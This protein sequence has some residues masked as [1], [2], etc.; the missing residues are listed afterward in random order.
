MSTVTQIRRPAWLVIG[1]IVGL[2]AILAIAL[3]LRANPSARE[4]ASARGMFDNPIPVRTPPANVRGEE[5]AILTSPPFVPPPITRNYPTKVKVELEVTEV[6]KRL[7]DG[8]DYT[9]W[10]FGGTVPG[11][12]IRVREGDLVEFTLQNHH[13]SEVPHNIDLHAVSGPGGGAAAT[14]TMPG[15]E[16][17]FSF[18][19]L[20]PGLYI[21]HCATAPVGVHVANGMYGLILVEPKEGMPAVD[22]EF[23]V[24]QGDFYT[25]GAFGEQGYQPFDMQKA[26]AEL[27]DY[28][29][30][31]GSVGALAG[32]NALQANVGET[33]RM[34]LGNGGPNL[35]S[36]FHVI[37]VVFD[38]YY[39][40]GG[41]SVTHN[42]Q[43]AV[44]P[45]G[46]SAIAEFRT[47]VPG[48]MHLVDHAIFRAFNKGAVGTLRVTGDENYT[49]FSGQQTNR[50]YTSSTVLAD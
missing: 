34:Y 38:N 32:D 10:T 12:F 27:A 36:S 28:V 30:F 45:P 17:S 50:P 16:T 19:A 21:Y 4:G 3:N 5:I 37:G 8:V 13:T 43:T 1:A 47:T 31:N 33:V 42:T 7:A 9:F 23:Y 15:H 39:I 6:T 40:E 20:H 18:T 35:T 26:I 22:R 46:G 2:L 44:I 41:A 24:V 25:R 48:D 49:I 11:S 29:V 14:L